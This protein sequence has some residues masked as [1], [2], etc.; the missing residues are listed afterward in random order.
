VLIKEK[1]DCIVIGSHPGALLAACLTAHLG[2]SVLILPS[3]DQLEHEVK[4]DSEPNYLIGLGGNKKKD[5]LLYQLFD[6]LGVIDKVEKL[7]ETIHTEP[8][9]VTPQ[10][11]LSLESELDLNRELNRE[12][13]EALSQNFG[14]G[15]ALK[16]TEQ[17]HLI[18]WKELPKKLLVTRDKADPVIHYG[19][20]VRDLQK[21]FKKK[22]PFFDKTIT[23]WLKPQMKLTQFCSQKGKGLHDLSC[24]L[25]YALTAHHNSNPQMF[26]LLHLL[27]LSRTGCSIKEGMGHYRKFLTELAKSMGVN[28]LTDVTCEG[29]R[30]EGRQVTGVRLGAKKE[31]IPTRAVVLGCSLMK[32]PRVYA[33]MKKSWALR[34]KMAERPQGWR[35]TL[36]LTVN[37]GAI[38][39]R[40]KKRMIWQEAGAPPLEFEQHN[41]P[42][43]KEDQCL[44]HLRTQVPFTKES[45]E[46]AFQKRIGKRMVKQAAELFPFLEDQ[47]QNIEFGIKNYSSLEAIP[48]T[49][50]IYGS[51]GIGSSAGISGLYVASHQSY[52]ELGSLGPTVAAVESVVRLLNQ[53]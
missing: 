11:R 20:R 33:S 14:L 7:V 41:S 30:V 2:L 6:F 48:D 3:P 24:G 29:L 12:L 49:A 27:S 8:Q 17:E 16:K 9:V 34:R 43:G 19:L 52:P 47:T 23:S 45:L 40:V 13:G 36:A 46:S 37:R 35:Y 22:Q 38:P 28:V 10:F 51:E 31:F 42:E 32:I 5:G 53:S 15:E 21:I 25:W 4:F 1:Y 39:E 44:L 18:F 26:S 50:L